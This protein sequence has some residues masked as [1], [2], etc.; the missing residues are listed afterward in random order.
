MET[1]SIRNSFA[2]SAMKSG[3]TQEA[4]AGVITVLGAVKAG[5]AG[6]VGGGGFV[7]SGGKSVLAVVSMDVSE[8]T[9]TV[10]RLPADAS[11]CN[12]RSRNS[13]A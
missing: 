10:T 4:V 9:A 12:L 6:P 2:S 1:G 5:P 7:G 8:T 11:G 13:G 3:G